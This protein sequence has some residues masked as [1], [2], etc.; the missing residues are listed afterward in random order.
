LL[1]ITGRCAMD[2][3]RARRRR[4]VPTDDVVTLDGAAP[5]GAAVDP[6]AELT[7]SALWLAVRALPDR[8][9]TA[10]ALRYLADLDHAV[11]AAQMGTTPSATRR[12]VSDALAA[13]RTDPRTLEPR[14]EDA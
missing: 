7:D 10:V 5:G 11:I 4:A 2:A 8:Q 1:T 3:H 13:L 14:T 9:R 12:L 6:G